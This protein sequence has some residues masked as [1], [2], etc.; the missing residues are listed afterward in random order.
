LQ[1][2]KLA[3]LLLKQ[4][5]GEVAHAVDDKYIRA[6]WIFEAIVGSATQNINQKSWWEFLEL[7]TNVKKYYTNPKFQDCDIAIHHETVPSC[8]KLIKQSRLEKID[9]VN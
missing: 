6:V 9:W 8:R 3:I 7:H 2:P 4:I 1:Q 5:L